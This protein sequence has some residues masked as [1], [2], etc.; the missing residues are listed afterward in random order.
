M[1]SKNQTPH[2]IR[3]RNQALDSNS[4]LCSWPNSKDCLIVD[5]GLDPDLMITEIENRRLIPKAIVST[6]GHFDH[7][8]S[9]EL[10][11]SKYKVPFYIHRQEKKVVNSAN[12]LMM[13]CKVSGKII[14][15][16]PD[17]WVDDNFE[18][19][20]LPEKVIFIPAPGHTPGSCFINVGNAYFT[21]DTIYRKTIGLVKLPGEDSQMMKKSILNQWNKIADTSMLY[22]GHGGHDT[23][24]QIKKINKDLHTFL[25][26][27]FGTEQQDG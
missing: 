15:P 10:L 1:P 27:P 6:H 25:D 11:K 18:L 8:G 23:F 9:A 24:L 17:L 4:Y 5:P 16:K 2:V 26:L 14:T 21:G 3:V 22:P 7:I 20:N 13:A 12:F 19:D